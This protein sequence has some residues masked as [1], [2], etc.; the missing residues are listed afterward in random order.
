MGAYSSQNI[1]QYLKV[2][3]IKREVGEGFPVLLETACF[4]AKPCLALSLVLRPHLLIRGWP[5]CLEA[6]GIGQYLLSLTCLAS[7]GVSWELWE[8]DRHLERHQA[9]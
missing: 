1:Y 4:G 5:S 6:P 7:V 8:K 9:S 3:R 2:I